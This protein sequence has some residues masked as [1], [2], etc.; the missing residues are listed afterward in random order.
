MLGAP[1]DI[2]DRDARIDLSSY[3]PLPLKTAPI[4]TRKAETGGNVTET[5]RAG[6]RGDAGAV[7]G[8]FLDTLR[9]LAPGP[10]TELFADQ[11]A[12]IAGQGNQEEHCGMACRY[13]SYL[14][15]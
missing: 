2:A 4:D 10:A 7:A 11:M 6:E 13:I 1:D 8:G 12:R 5:G 14:K 9:D 15:R 3:K